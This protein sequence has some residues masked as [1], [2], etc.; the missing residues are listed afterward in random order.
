M[1]EGKSTSDPTKAAVT[2][3]SYHSGYVNTLMMDGSVSIAED[4]ID[5]ILWQHMGTRNGGE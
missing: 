3:R 2:A 4:N 5:P 1:Q